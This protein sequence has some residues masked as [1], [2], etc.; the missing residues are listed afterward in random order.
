MP[1]ITELPAEGGAGGSGG[2]DREGTR[3]YKPPPKKTPTEEEEEEELEE[4]EEEEEETET[5]VEIPP[6]F[7]MEDAEATLAE[8]AKK[9]REKQRL[10]EQLDDER[11]NLERAYEEYMSHKRQLK[12]KV[13]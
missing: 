9:D 2:E 3:G 5:I 13:L 10:L 12:M 11:L 6:E 1:N 4:E 7:G 8:Q